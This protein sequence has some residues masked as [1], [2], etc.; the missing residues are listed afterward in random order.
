ML[1]NYINKLEAIIDKDEYDLSN[2]AEKIQK[3]EEQLK[4]SS[5]QEIED[6]QFITTEKKFSM[7]I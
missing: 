5:D 4:L 1:D 3:R 2:F 6:P 7:P